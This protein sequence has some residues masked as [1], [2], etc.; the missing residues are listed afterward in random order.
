MGLAFLSPEMGFEL[1]GRVV[2]VGVVMMVVVAVVDFLGRAFRGGLVCG[3]PLTLQ[4]KRSHLTERTLLCLHI[5]GSLSDSLGSP[6]SRQLGRLSQAQ[7]AS[8]F[9]RGRPVNPSGVGLNIGQ[10]CSS[11]RLAWCLG[12][13]K[14]SCWWWFHGGC[15]SR[16]SLLGRMH[17]T[18]RLI[19]L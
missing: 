3:S 18:H 7:T 10:Q 4:S 16:G 15:K 6:K 1:V 12:F 17:P 8:G 19:S 2:G 14:L 5:C 9:C 11:I 13:G